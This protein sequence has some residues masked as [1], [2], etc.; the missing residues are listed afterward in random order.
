MEIVDF[1]EIA[2]ESY[3]WLIENAKGLNAAK[4]TSGIHLTELIYCL[5]GGYWDKI[6]PLPATKQQALLMALGIGFERLIIPVEVRAAPG[7]CEG[8]E[9]SPD[10]WFRGEMPSELKTTRLSTK[11]TRKRDFPES[12]IQQIMGYCYAVKKLEYGLSIVHLM[13]GYSPPFPE[14]LGIKFS[15][16][17]E[18]LKNNWDFL[19]WRKN[20]YIQGFADMQPPTPTKW[21]M[22]WECKYCRYEKSAIHCNIKVV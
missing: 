14:I 10:F 21:C 3:K 17:Q 8:I 13:G 18:E 1:P 12:W 2:D 16:T 9:Y 11:K 7:T 15:F 22:D 4:R 19:M 20:V 5:T 6:M